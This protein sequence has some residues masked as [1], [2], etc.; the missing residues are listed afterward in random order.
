MGK[1]DA[2]HSQTQLDHIFRLIAIGV[3]TVCASVYAA[4]KVM[5]DLLRKDATANGMGWAQH[6]ASTTDG[7]DAVVSGYAPASDVEAF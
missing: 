2:K 6:V 1:C 3:A 7:L 5:D 4:Q